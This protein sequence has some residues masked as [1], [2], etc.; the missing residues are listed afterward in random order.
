MEYTI[1][2]E[3][4]NLATDNI[5][6]A[7]RLKNAS[8][9]NIAIASAPE[10]IKNLEMYKTFVEKAKIEIAGG[11]GVINYKPKPIIAKVEPETTEIELEACEI[12]CENCSS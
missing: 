1:K 4:I 7:I 9:L 11:Y 12:G 10:V 6:K 2:I 8:L 3:D 5:L